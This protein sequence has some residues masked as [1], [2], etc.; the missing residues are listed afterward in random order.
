METNETQTE[1]TNTEQNWLQKEA[2][3]ANESKFDGET[4]PALTL[5]ENKP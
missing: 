3:E 1:Q 5:E 2:E 4:L